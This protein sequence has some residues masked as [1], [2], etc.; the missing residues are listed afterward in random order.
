[1][2][3][4]AGLTGKPASRDH[5]GDVYLADGS[6]GDKGLT[7]DGFEC[8]ETE[9]VVD[10]AVVD[11]YDAGSAGIDV[12]AGDRRFTAPCAVMVSP[13]RLIHYA[14]PPDENLFQTTGFCEACG[15][16]APL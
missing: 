16:S 11:G 8:F 10:V 9:I 15:C 3:D 1:V 7:D 13:F 6:G 5:C 12:D 2:A 14:P 4:C